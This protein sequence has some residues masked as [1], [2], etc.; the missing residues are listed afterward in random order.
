MTAADDPRT[1]VIHS[2]FQRPDQLA[3]YAALGMSPTYFTNHAYFWGDVH[4]ANLGADRAAF[5]SPMKS[6]A[7]QG[8]VVSNHSDFNVTPLDPMFILWTSMARTSRSGRTSASTRTQA[9]RR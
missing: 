9:C 5:I 2:Q 7:A 1:V 3:K 8:L 6:A 4:R